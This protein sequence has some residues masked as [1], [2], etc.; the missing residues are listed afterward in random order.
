MGIRMLHHRTTPARAS[1][2]RPARVLFL[3]VPVFAPGAS[4]GRTPTT[5]ATAL[6]RTATDLR[7][8]LTRR[9]D[10]DDRTAAPTPPPGAL[11]RHLWVDL[12]RGY[13][14]LALTLMPRTRP[15]HSFTV[16]V[17]STDTLSAR[18]G[19]PAPYRRLL[20]FREPGPDATP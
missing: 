9:V 1:T 7:R 14:A 2:D 18:P 10:R 4:T 17:A 15:A 20:G 11:A 5:L 16:F 8:R 13:L 3:P 19:G 12:A 6:R